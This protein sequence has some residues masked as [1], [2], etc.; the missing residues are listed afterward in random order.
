MRIGIIPFLVQIILIKAERLIEI[1]LKK[2]VQQYLFFLCEPLS[3]H[4]IS[5]QY[6]VQSGHHFFHLC[7]PLLH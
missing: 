4:N 6:F 3:F 1:H 2:M 5:L 7:L